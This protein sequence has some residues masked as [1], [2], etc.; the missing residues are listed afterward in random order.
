MPKQ[1]P[2]PYLSV[3]VTTRNDDHGH[4]P[5]GR[6][7]AFINCLAAQS[8]RAQLQTELIV[9]EWNPPPDRPRLREVLTWPLDGSPCEVRIVEVPA[10]LHGTLK[11]PEALPLYQMIAKN[12]GIRRARGEF[13]LATNIDILLSN[14]LIDAIAARELK[15]GVMYRVD[16]VDV[17]AGVP[18]AAPL[19]ELMSYCRTHQLR[20]H[21]RLGSFPTTRTGEGALFPRDIVAPGSDIRLGSG[22]HVHEGSG[23]STFRW[24]M[25][26]AEIL[27]DSRSESGRLNIEVHANPSDRGSVVALS[28]AD[29]ETGELLPRTEL[30]GM[31]TVQVVVPEGQGT[32]RLQLKA[33]SA[34]NRDTL[35]LYEDRDELVYQVAGIWWDTGELALASQQPGLQYPPRGWHSPDG[36][37]AVEPTGDDVSVVTGPRHRVYS[38][39]YGP[40]E[41]PAAG[42]YR[43]WITM[44]MLEGG[45]IVQALSGDRLRWLD[46]T[47]RTF[48]RGAGMQIVELT[49]TLPAHESFFIMLSNDHQR[50][51]ERSRLVIHDLVGSHPCER[52]MPHA[53][54]STPA[55]AAAEEPTL[56]RR[57]M[58]RM[59][60]PQPAADASAP[61]VQYVSTAPE[62]YHQLVEAHRRLLPL[63]PLRALLAAVRPDRVHTHAC[64]DFQLM[65]RDDWFEL[66]GYAEFEMYSM[67]IDSLLSHT[68]R[69][70]GMTEQ[71]FAAP[72][73]I[74][75]IE[76]EIG[77]GWT[78]EGEVTLR[79]RLAARGIGWLDHAL[80]QLMAGLMKWLGGPMIFNRSGWGF[81]R[82]ELGETTV[83][84]HVEH[85]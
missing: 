3:V 33:F 24:A 1:P 85:A 74:Y 56:G 77:S 60:A 21:T 13:V 82:H 15:P 5:L 23:D 36:G 84:A 71:V 51:G 35:P 83:S 54:A 50:E 73:C 55:A 4:N 20:R 49:V 25:E 34:V 47:S 58:D 28:I 78:P 48:H 62:G 19:D 46:A 41:A 42:T 44:S 75:H 43:F 14:Q 27:V 66:R 45:V 9:V 81:A 26:S 37:G 68:A 64:G 40:L 61:V 10:A 76:H 80:V 70:S 16:R 39:E 67:N 12:V 72:E 2:A 32:R 7:Q 17:D 18:A 63:E 11:H 69:Y 38:A 22:W 52:M 79:Q 6:F 8:L 59:R 65:S 57:L 53:A 31:V 30:K 29:V